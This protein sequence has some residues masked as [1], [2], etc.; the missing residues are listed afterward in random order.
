MRLPAEGDWRVRVT[1][2]KYAVLL[3][4]GDRLRVNEG[5]KRL[6][7]GV[8]R[9]EVIIESPKHDVTL[10]QQ[11]V[12]EVSDIFSVYRQRFFE[13]FDDKRIQHVI[14]F[15]NHGPSS[16]TSIEHPHSQL[17]GVPVMPFQSRSRVDEAMRFFD[18]TGECL[19]CA[20]LTDELADRKRIIVESKHFVSFIPYAA[21][22]PFHTWV[23]PQRHTPSFG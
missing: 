23:F 7:T 4:E 19:N 3:A 6:V 22:S 13:A 5:L 20:M 17:I 14:I 15:K 12:D 8:G 21:L 11:S 18:N 10:A 9:H 2:N 16:G 1:P